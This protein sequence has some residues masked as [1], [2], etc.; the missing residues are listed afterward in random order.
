MSTMSNENLLETCLRAAI[1]KVF[2][3]LD[4]KAFGQ[5]RELF[6]WVEMSGGDCLFRQGDEG[7]SMFVLAAGRLRVSRRR[8]SG[9]A[10]HLDDIVPGETVGEMA[11]ITGEPRTADITALRDSVLARLS[12][13]NFERLA[14]QYPHALLHISRNIIERLQNRGKTKRTA[15]PVRNLCLLPITPR[16]DTQGIARQICDHLTA[17]GPVL[18]LD[19]TAVNEALQQQ[20]IAETE[21][22]ER[23]AYH[24]L[25]AWLEMQEAQHRFV[26]YLPDADDTE[27]T[28]RCFRQAD[29]ILLLADATAAPELHVF[30]RKYLRGEGRITSAGQRLVLLHSPQT[31]APHH[32]RSWLAKRDLIFYHH[33]KMGDSQSFERLGRFLAGK[34]VGLVLSGGA[35]RGFAHIGV[36]RALDEA[37][38]PVDMVGG[39]SIGAVMGAL[40]ARGWSGEQ[41]RSHCRQVFRTS[42]T[43]DFNWMP[44]NSI[45]RG[46]KLNRLLRENFDDQQIEDCW[47]N[48]FCVSC[49]LTKIHPH[50]HRSGSLLDAIRASISIPGVFPPAELHNDLHVDGGVFNNMP[51][52][53][54]NQSGVDTLI[55]VDLQTN[56]SPDAP[57]ERGKNDKRRMP[58]LLF[59]VMESTMLSGRYLTQEHKKEVDLYFNPPLRDFSL[60]DWHKFEE[61]ERIGYEHAKGVLDKAK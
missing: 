49:N 47:L 8:T 6:D 3:A 21:R 1:V 19:S 50:V 53:V 7:D 38:I 17:H 57:M 27:W 52:D 14:E 60:I 58:N 5:V 16:L 30:E 59:V 44:W 13:A 24:G 18:Q 22:S 29:E 54:M 32:T 25:T 2:G 55:A 42:P 46:K 39:T 34:A 26:V 40:T 56:R 10:D 36:L 35:A 31:A 37:G 43:S 51:V 33:L 61:I 48:Y 11:L 4:T 9:I 15:K 12:K 28:R 41:M 20:N 45:F 23:S